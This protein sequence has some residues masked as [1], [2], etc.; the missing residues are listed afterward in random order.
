MEKLGIS[1]KRDDTMARYEE[2]FER[3]LAEL[4]FGALMVLPSAKA[5]VRAASGEVAAQA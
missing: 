3:P 4:W 1:P 5:K 2:A